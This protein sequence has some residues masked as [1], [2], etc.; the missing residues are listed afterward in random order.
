[1]VY[2]L[3]LVDITTF[4]DFLQTAAQLRFVIDSPPPRHVYVVRCWI[5]RPEYERRHELEDERLA[6]FETRVVQFVE[7]HDLR[8]LQRGRA[9]AVVA[10]ATELESIKHILTQWE[11]LD[12]GCGTGKLLK[13]I[14]T[15]H[16][17]Q[18]RGIDINPGMLEVARDYHGIHGATY[19]DVRNFNLPYRSYDMILAF[20]ELTP[21][22]SPGAVALYR[23]YNRRLPNLISLE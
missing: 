21:G 11:I 6:V 14:L 3:Q 7:V 1:M 23:L 2:R 13:D 22:S 17:V 4:D 16:S 15:D 5:L 10:L 12:V 20:R 19:A 18:V 9:V 8:V